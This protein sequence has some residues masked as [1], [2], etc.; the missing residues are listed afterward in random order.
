MEHGAK[1]FICIYITPRNTL[2]ELQI[3]SKDYG[4][5]PTDLH[6]GPLLLR[7]H[8]KLYKHEKFYL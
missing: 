3:R 8:R 6:I 5:P 4:L 1:C 7:I 2:C